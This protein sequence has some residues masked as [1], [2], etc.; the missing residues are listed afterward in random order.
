MAV[1]N[2]HRGT[3]DQTH[4]SVLRYRNENC[5]L[6]LPRENDDGGQRS[7][8][9]ESQLMTPPHPRPEQ[10]PPPVPSWRVLSTAQPHTGFQAM[11]EK[12]FP[13]NSP[14]PGSRWLLRVEGTGGGDGGG[15][16]T[17]GGNGRG[18]GEASHSESE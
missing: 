7:N 1:R 16:R 11:E 4:N 2:R 12:F 6:H 10:S 3:V 5:H 18:E 9:T 8:F 15:R 14:E 17:G 13:R